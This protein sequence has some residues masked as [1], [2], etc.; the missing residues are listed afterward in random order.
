M[1]VILLAVAALLSGCASFSYITESYGN[2]TLVEVTTRYDTFRVFDKPTE[3]KLMITSS[4]GSALT[5]GFTGGLLLNPTATQT[6]KPIF[7]EGAEQFLAQ[8]GRSCRIV[9]GYLLVNPQ[10]EFKYECEGGPIAT[11]SITKTN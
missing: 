8:T 3:G 6:P 10:W 4:I 2:V 1:R 11:S 9:D 5:T 7:Q